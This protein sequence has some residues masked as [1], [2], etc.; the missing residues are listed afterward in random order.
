MTQEDLPAGEGSQMRV[1]GATAR[2]RSEA[3]GLKPIPF[4]GPFEDK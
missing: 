4:G 3:V 2:G 1:S